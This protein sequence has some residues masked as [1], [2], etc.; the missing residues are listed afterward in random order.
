MDTLVEKDTSP[1]LSQEKVENLNCLIIKEWIQWSEV[2]PQK[3]PGLDRQI[4]PN[5]PETN[6]SNLALA[7]PDYG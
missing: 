4:L 7:F 1:K 6:D 3:I 5:I 2:F